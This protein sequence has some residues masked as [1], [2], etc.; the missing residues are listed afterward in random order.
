MLKQKTLV[1]ILLSL[2]SK[3]SLFLTFS[4]CLALTDLI[5]RQATLAVRE[6]ELLREGKEIEDGLREAVACQAHNRQ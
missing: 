2:H 3:R 6:G 1:F 4:F 5:Q